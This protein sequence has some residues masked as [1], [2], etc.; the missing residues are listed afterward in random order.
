MTNY[1]II[2]LIGGLYIAI[3][4]GYAAYRITKSGSHD[5]PE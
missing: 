5:L 2:G 3:L 1:E 4:M